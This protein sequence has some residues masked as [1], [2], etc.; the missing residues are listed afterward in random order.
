MAKPI[1]V[2]LSVEDRKALARIRE[3][4]G[5]AFEMLKKTEQVG[6]GLS[7]VF[8]TLGGRVIA[9][10]QGFEL[11][12]RTITALKQNLL[13]AAEAE[14]LEE[15]FAGTAAELE[16]LRKATA[17]TVL[18]S[19]L[20][21]L[22]N[23][24]QALGLSM[25]QQIILFAAAE[26]AGDRFGVGVEESFQKIVYASEGA[27]RGLKDL[28]IQKEQFEGKLEELAAAEGGVIDSLDAETQKRLRLQAIL[29]LTSITLEDVANKEMDAKDKLEAVGV[30][31]EQLQE[32]FGR[33]VLNGIRPLVEILNY[34]IQGANDLLTVLRG[35][36]G[37]IQVLLTGI[38]ALAG[39]FL[40]LQSSAGGIPFLLVGIVTGITGLLAAI[41]EGNGWIAAL[42]GGLGA[43]AIG[44]ALAGTSMTAFKGILITVKVAMMGLLDTIRLVMMYNPWIALLAG[45]GAVAGAVWALTSKTDEL[46]D[47][48]ERET[49]EIRKQQSEFNTLIDVVKSD[50]TERGAKLRAI[51]ELTKKYP[52]YLGKLNLETASVKELAAAQAAANEAFE[53]GVALKVSDIRSQH[54]YNQMAELENQ[55]ARDNQ[56]LAEMMENSVSGVINRSLYGMEKITARI[57]ER[58]KQLAELRDEAVKIQKD[59]AKLAAGD[60]TGTGNQ[61]QGTIGAEIKKLDS[62]IAAKKAAWAKTRVEN[63]KEREALEKE[64]GDLETKKANLEYKRVDIYHHRD[65]SDNRSELVKKLEGIKEELRL[66]ELRGEQQGEEAA[67]LVKLSGYYELLLDLSAKKNLTMQDEIRIREERSRLMKEYEGMEFGDKLPVIRESAEELKRGLEKLREPLTEIQEVTPIEV[68][69]AGAQLRMELFLDTLDAIKEGAEEAGRVIA[70]QFSSA[71]QVFRQANSVL[72]MMLNTF[73]M[74]V[75]QALTLKGISKLFSLIGLAGGGVAGATES[76]PPAPSRAAGGVI[77]GPGTSTSDSIFAML[78]NGEYVVNAE[79]TRK[80]KPLLD[81]INFGVMGK[82][83][84]PAFAQGGYTGGGRGGNSV[85][86]V[87]SD[88]VVQTVVLETELSGRDI[89]IASKRDYALKKRL[90]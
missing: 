68:V 78:S 83:M 87:K 43:L 61:E 2:E 77:T 55:N 53:K 46:S 26:E 20:I 6:K 30:G 85:V 65:R 15:I 71:V 28:G 73:V 34:L 17:G 56:M 23:Q 66:L 8:D 62:E 51:E 84:I 86:I 89:R 50:T 64:I 21:K 10:N 82:T 69:S 29:Q 19:N 31:V 63:K 54:L 40:L 25:E 35:L 3:F 88:P 74:V 13:A 32:N 67:F 44:I 41:R 12:G 7:G 27:T 24:A 75:V 42:I 4:D 16:M 81:M 76:Q 72:E 60:T 9:L 22:S 79:S 52:E 38:I 49:G 39:S 33:L 11:I 1:I 48:V 58:D 36:P 37:Y 45:I 59:S 70:S 80:Y 5:K 14:V 90:G 47:S 57:R 18:D